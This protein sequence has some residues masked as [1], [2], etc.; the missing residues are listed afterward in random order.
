MRINSVSQQSFG[1]RPDSNTRR[2]LF[3]LASN[4]IDTKPHTDIINEV[5]VGDTLNTRYLYDGS[6]N[7]DIYDENGH[8]KYA[9]LR[10]Y[11]KP[12]AD[13]GSLM[14][15]DPD[16]FSTILYNALKNLAIKR[17][18]NQKIADKVNSQL[19]EI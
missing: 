6:I 18:D 14:L 13:I 19:R 7:M 2:I 3:Q 16:K 1:A 15:K 8:H 4:G 10:N 11:D 17:S 12:Y 9:I 5:Y